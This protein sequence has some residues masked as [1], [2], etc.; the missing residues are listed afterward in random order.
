[1]I[2]DIELYFIISCKKQP[3]DMIEPRGEVI[4]CI[5]NERIK[6]KSYVHGHE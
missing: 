5:F 1:M 3:V 2:H 6:N 4:I